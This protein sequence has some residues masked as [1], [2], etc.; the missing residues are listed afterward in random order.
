MQ[1][2][3]AFFIL[4]FSVCIAKNW[5]PVPSGRLIPFDC[6]HEVPSS[7]RARQLKDGTILV[8]H[9]SI[10]T[11]II[12]ECSTWKHKSS[13]NLT[14]NGWIAW[15]IVTGN[16]FQDFYGWFQVPPSPIEQNQLIY[17]FIGLENSAYS[18]II[19]P[20]LQWGQ[21]PAGGGSYWSIA[22]WWVT[23]S[24][25]GL[26][27]SLVPVNVGDNI[28]VSL[29]NLGGGS[30]SIVSL[31]LTN[32]KS[33]IL[34]VENVSTQTVAVVSLEGYNIESCSGYPS[35]GSTTFYGLSLI[36]NGDQF[37]G[38]WNGNTLYSNCNER[39]VSSKFSTCSIYF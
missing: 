26:F 27:S 6:I 33:S 18:E 1:R 32:S 16:N 19:Q 15:G 22:S 13:K 8:E 2:L 20:V 28:I 34:N 24:G 12:P 21:S 23:S 37:T 31:D 3:G 39:I 4:L 35:S 5:V 14:D 17:L 11:K 7:S 29:S 30:W 10:G 38:D 9:P 36:D 25:Q